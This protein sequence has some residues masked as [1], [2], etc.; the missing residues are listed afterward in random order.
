MDGA[1]A[2]TPEDQWVQATNLNTFPQEAAGGTATA[3]VLFFQPASF[4]GGAV[5]VDN[6]EVLI[7]GEEPTDG[8]GGGPGPDPCP[9]DVDNDT[10]CGFGDVLAVLSDWQG[11][12][13]DVDGDGTVGFGDVLAVLSN[14]G[15]CD[16][17]P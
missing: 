17:T 10:I 5:W 8:G 6:V 4:D 3:V 11:T 9:C 15:P 13:T 14:W 16:K 7:N 1:D 2:N 12:D